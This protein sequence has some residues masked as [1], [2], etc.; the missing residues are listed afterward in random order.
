MSAALAEAIP[1]TVELAISCLFFVI[2]SLGLALRICVAAWTSKELESTG[3]RV[4]ITL[5]VVMAFS[6]ITLSGTKYVQWKMPVLALDQRDLTVNPPSAPWSEPG[7]Q[8]IVQINKTEVIQQPP[9]EIAQLQFSFWSDQ[10]TDFPLKAIEAQQSDDGSIPFS[11]TFKNVS[12]APAEVIDVWVHLCSDCSFAK[13]P[14]GFDK[15][16]GQDEQSRHRVFPLLNEG[17]SMEKMSVE[18]KLDS[19]MPITGRIAGVSFSYSCK[20]CGGVT[21]TEDFRVRIVPSIIVLT[22]QRLTSSAPKQAPR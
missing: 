16:K 18:F 22:R 4:F 7:E 15:P 12:K 17:V 13:E 20:S 14:E 6:I 11:F 9:P 10:A 2:G 19:P 5:F 8:S 1:N 3:Q 21:T